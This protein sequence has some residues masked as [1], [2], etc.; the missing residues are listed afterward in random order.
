MLMQAMTLYQL[1]VLLLMEG[2]GCH[3]GI[4]RVLSNPASSVLQQTGLMP[5]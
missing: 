4:V 5:I 3:V 1:Y 2:S